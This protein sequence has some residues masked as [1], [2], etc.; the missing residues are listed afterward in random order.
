MAFGCLLPDDQEE[1]V[2]KWWWWLRGD[3][4]AT[5]GCEGLSLDNECG[6]TFGQINLLLHYG[7]ADDD[8][9]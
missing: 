8:A 6:R 1:V 9:R 2:H 4:V 5:P 7:T 3:T